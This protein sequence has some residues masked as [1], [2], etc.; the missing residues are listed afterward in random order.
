MPHPALAVLEEPAPEL[1]AAEGP[2]PR[3]IHASL[4]PASGA[5]DRRAASAKPGSARSPEAIAAARA[6]AVDH[7]FKA[8]VAAANALRGLGR[9][10]DLAN[11]LADELEQTQIEAEAIAARGGAKAAQPLR[12]ISEGSAS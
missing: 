4:L 9:H 11:M 6:R 2:S 1:P 7:H 5:A 8:L 12:V 10:G 3:D